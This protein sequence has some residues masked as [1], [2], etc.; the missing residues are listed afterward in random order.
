MEIDVQKDGIYIK[1]NL[2]YIGDDLLIVISGGDKPHIGSTLLVNKNELKSISFNS[3][4]DYIALEKIAKI[5]KKNTQK[6]IALI[7]GIHIENITKKQITQVL[8]LSEE[9]AQKIL[10]TCM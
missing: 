6:N 8:E 1:A 4:K 7:G 5:L 10:F 9:L 2:S 3:H